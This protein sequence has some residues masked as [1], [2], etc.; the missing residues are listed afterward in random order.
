MATIINQLNSIARD[1]DTLN[2]A[3]RLCCRIYFDSYRNEAYVHKRPKY[4]GDATTTTISCYS[5]E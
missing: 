1:L 5:S 2:L 4:D 3:I